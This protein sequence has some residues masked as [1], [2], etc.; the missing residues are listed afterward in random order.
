MRTLYSPGST[1][2]RFISMCHD[3]EILFEFAVQ[4]AIRNGYRI[5]GEWDAK[6]DIPAISPIH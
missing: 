4:E 6:N 5:S 2:T 1:V 3:P